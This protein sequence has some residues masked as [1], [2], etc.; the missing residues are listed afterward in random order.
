[1]E[2]VE[3][4]IMIERSFTMFRSLL[5]VALMLAA[6]V[7]Y[8]G[9]ESR[10]GTTGADQ[11]LIPVGARS[12]ATGGAFLAATKGVEAIYYSALRVL[13]ETG[14]RVYDEEGV[15]VAYSGGA[16]V[17][18]TTEDSSLVKIPAWM[19]DRARATLPKKVDLVGPN[20]KY[21]M[22]LYKNQIYFGTGS[23]TPYTLDPSQ[24]RGRLSRYQ[25]VKNAAR[26]AE[27]LPTL[28]LSCRS[29]SPKTRPSAPTIVGST[30]RCSKG[31]TSRSTL[32]LWIWR[33]CEISSRWPISVSVAKR[34]GAKAR[35]MD[36]FES[37][38]R[39]LGP[40]AVIAEDLGIITDA[41][42]QLRD[43]LGFP[44]MK[45]LQFAFSGPDN[46]F[47]PHSYPRNC[48]VYTGT[49]DNDT[50]S[51]WFASAPEPEVDFARRYLHVDG[52]TF[53]WD[54]IRTAWSSVASR[55]PD[56]Q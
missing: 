14:V 48:A 11:L 45:I 18:D 8:G 24:E 17:Q 5:C 47:L 50:S 20:R 13:E 52:S 32:R 42:H 31:P 51:G 10:K 7:A 53:A 21:R 9:D 34:N 40:V 55:F 30:L 33:E 19:V 16:I 56:K 3:F 39:E 26:I 25:D 35:G 12:I 36:L 46:P 38:R 22:E 43:A 4:S 29:V 37:V 6:T 27:V 28:T 23:D 54:L 49:H 2:E 44:G 41:V 15:Q 1:M